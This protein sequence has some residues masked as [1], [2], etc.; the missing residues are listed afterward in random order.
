NA[1]DWSGSYRGVLPCADCPGIDT[2]ISLTSDGRY[3][4]QR[5]YLEKGDDIYRD[6][7]SFRW[8]A[9]GNEITLQGKEKGRYRVEENRL[10]QLA[11]DGSTITGPLAEHYVLQKSKEG[12]TEKY[13]KLVELNGQPVAQLKR[14]PHIILRA[15]DN[16]VTGF[17]GCNGLLGGYEL[18][19]KTQRI[20]FVGVAS[21][22]M[23]CTEGMDVEGALHEVLRSVDNYSLNG[24]S[25]TLN[26]ARMAPLARFEAVYLK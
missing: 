21:T 15:E 4:Y 26:K 9:A 5:R 2:N 22:L 25:L 24:D 12:I 23:A 10:V 6:E 3:K 14:E 11:L 1:L 19:E 7:G 20:R 13:W 8:N 17:G 18:D 16:R